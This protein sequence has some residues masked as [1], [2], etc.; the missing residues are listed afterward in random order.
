MLYIFDFIE[1]L[2]WQC[3]N[4][5]SLINAHFNQQY[6]NYP[7]NKTAKFFETQSKRINSFCLSKIVIPK[8]KGNEW[9]LKPTFATNILFLFEYKKMTEKHR[10]YLPTIAIKVEGHFTN[11]AISLFTKNSTFKHKETKNREVGPTGKEASTC[12]PSDNDSSNRK[13]S[14]Q[15]DRY[16]IPR[17]RD[18]KKTHRSSIKNGQIP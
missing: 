16:N 8:R 18:H 3:N 1:I 17:S 10:D 5:L 6:C 7:A 15:V 14:S 4:V 11:D 9:R 13:S 12:F 2:L